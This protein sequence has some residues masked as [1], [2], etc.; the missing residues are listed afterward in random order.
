M[1]RS[2][3]FLLVGLCLAF[4]LLKPTLAQV[5]VA[6]RLEAATSACASKRGILKEW[7][8]DRMI[9][10]RKRT[11]AVVAVMAL[12][13]LAVPLAGCSMDRWAKVEPGEYTVVHDGV[14]AT[15]TIAGEIQ[16][17]DVDRDKSLMVL[18]LVDGSEIVTSFV[19]R[20]RT[21]WPAG[22][23][24]NIQSTRME[25]LDIVQ[26][27]LT[28]GTASL[29]RPILVRDCPPDPV[30]IVLREDGA[31]GGGG[32]GCPDPEQCIYLAPRQ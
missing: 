15:M 18:T 10:G 4:T 25:V 31:I 22:C 14:A 3:R 19:P 26:A 20:D 2:A 17:L 21:K 1:P 13:L 23:P 8:V 12:A 28:I 9:S 30:R 11:A 6:Y 16:R 7:E 27:P 29:R 5:D 24:T 32:T